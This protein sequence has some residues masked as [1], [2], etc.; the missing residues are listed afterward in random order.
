MSGRLWLPDNHIGVGIKTVHLNKQLVQGL[1]TFVVAASRPAT[2]WRPTASILVTKTYRENAFLPGRTNPGRGWR[3]AHE[4]FDKFR[5]GN[6]EKW[7]TGLSRL[8]CH[9]QSLAC[10]WRTHQRTPLGM[11]AP[12]LMILGFLQ[13]FNHFQQFFLASSTPLRPRR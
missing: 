7:H 5:A 11:R 2:R 3:Y 9:H 1:F 10:T 4:H 13:E 6:G 8:L 12:R